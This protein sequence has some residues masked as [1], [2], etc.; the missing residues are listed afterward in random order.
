MY[1]VK[2]PILILIENQMLTLNPKRASE[3]SSALRLVSI[4][5]LK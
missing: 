2:E 5:V 4:R 1:Q 3:I